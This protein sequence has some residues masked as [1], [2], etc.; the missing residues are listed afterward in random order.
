MKKLF[1]FLTAMTL[2]TAWGGLVNIQ[3]GK[4]NAELKAIELDVQYGGGCEEHQFYLEI[5]RCAE[6]YP[7]QCHNVQL[8]DKNQT[9]HCRSIVNKKVILTLEETGLNKGYYNGAS[10][11][12][13]GS[14]GGK[15]HISLPFNK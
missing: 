14:G 10:L 4:Y 9:D 7:V 12:I 3:D 15:A 13:Y 6:S 5:D 2:N 1:F 11:I 8:I